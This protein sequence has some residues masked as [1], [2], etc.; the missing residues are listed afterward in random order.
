[1]PVIDDIDTLA[2]IILKEKQAGKVIITTNGCF[3]I[4]H[5]GHVRYLE[6]AK[7]QG[8]VLVIGVNS[9]RSVRELKGNGRPVNTQMDRAEI[10]SALRFVDYVCVF[11]ETN[12]ISFLSKIKTDIHVKG[13]DYKISEMI[14]KDVVEKNGGKIIVLDFVEGRSTTNI[15]NKI[16]E[17]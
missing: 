14:E 6:K 10:L 4:L 3:D 2:E 13:G 17:F 1:M 8:D 9:D 15:L 5:V 12:P 16:K 11:D 7:S